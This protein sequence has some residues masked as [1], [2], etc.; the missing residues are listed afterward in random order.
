MKKVL[1]FVF[2]SSMIINVGAL[3][4]KRAMVKPGLQKYQVEADYR[5]LDD[6]SEIDNA[7]IIPAKNANMLEE[8]IIGETYYDK[9]SNRCV[10]N[11]IYRFSD[12]TMGAT[13]TRGMDEPGFS[14][15]GTG[16]NYFDGN[17]WG[18]YP[19]ARIET[20]RAG[21]PTYAPLGENGEIVV[22]HNAV[23]A[24]LINRRVE[25][26]TGDWIETTLQGPPGYEKVTWPR[27]I[28][29]G[30]DHNTI[31]LLGQIRDGYNGQ[32]IALAY[33][34]STDGG[35]NWDI[36]NEVFDG[37]GPDAYTEIGAD[38]QVWAEPRAGVIAF[39][40]FNMWHDLFIYKSTDEGDTW[41]K[42]V[43]WE[44]PYPF[45]NDETVF[46][47]TLWVPDNSG[48]IALDSEGKVHM[49]FGLG[50]I[51][52]F[53]VGTTYTFWPG[54]S[55]GIAYWNEDMPPFEADNQHDALDPYDVL[56]EDVNLIGWSQDLDNSGAL[57]FEDIIAYSEIGLCTM[58]NIVV[59]D[60]NQIFV[61]YAA[62]TESYHNGTYNYKHIWSR[63]SPDGG[64]SWVPMHVDLTESLTHIFD[65]CV[66]PVLTPA[67]DDYI[68]MMYNQDQS[69]GN[70]VDEDHPYELNNEY[71]S[72]VAKPEILGI[73][74]SHQFTAANVMQNYPNPFSD[75][76]S[77]K[78]M[79]NQPANLS[80]E[81]SNIQGQ[82]VYSTEPIDAAPG[83]H[84]LTIEAADLKPGLYIYT[85]YAG[86]S[87]VN[88][89]MIIK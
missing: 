44:H 45:Y 4:Q 52:H 88:R 17:N 2:A 40:C 3:A 7:V 49:A 73:G 25:K 12:G 58:P 84:M 54:L 71:F 82:V 15:R 75:R 76:S 89:K 9:Q 23:D 64:M 34:R 14:D 20:E 53:E 18:P 28:T 42:T 81:V 22:S 62:T 32:D 83:S 1:L 38:A 70:A 60:L 57:E 10:T 55:N 8:E 30:P 63:G 27:V 61:V 59:D 6:G 39:A 31:H 47:D 78:V 5:L 79:L 66:Y 41:V 16:Y 33:Y 48:A 50:V 43:V 11:R 85:V 77:V 67:S 68:Y 21:W 87:K 56:L 19:T 69:P 80:L 13:W 36:Q 46:T 74:E 37:V 51:G 72:T 35:D 65:E 86:N 29:S 26:G 24:L